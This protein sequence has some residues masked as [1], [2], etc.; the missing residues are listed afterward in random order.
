MPID[1][2][3]SPT[4][5][6]LLMLHRDGGLRRQPVIAWLTLADGTVTGLV[7]LAFGWRSGD[8]PMRARLKAFPVDVV[9]N[10]DTMQSGEFDSVWGFLADDQPLPGRAS[11]AF[12]KDLQRARRRA[13]K[14]S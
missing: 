13:D 9:W 10:A 12:L 3:K 7:D 5:Y 4:G 11:V 6:S 2:S 14:A 1:R 8:E